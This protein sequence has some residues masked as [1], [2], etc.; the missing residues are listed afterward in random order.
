MDCAQGF[1]QQKKPGLRHC[2]CQGHTQGV[3]DYNANPKAWIANQ[4]NLDK[5][6]RLTGAKPEEIAGL[7]QGNGYPN[8]SEQS[9]LLGQSTVKAVAATSAFLKEQGKVDSVQPDYAP[10]VEARFARAAR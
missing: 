6:S 9:T 3:C 5:V 7:L 1:R 10:W 2:L 8:A 4:A